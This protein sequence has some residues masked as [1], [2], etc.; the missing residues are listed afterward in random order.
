MD[1]V[2]EKEYYSHEEAS[3]YRNAVVKLKKAL[4]D[5]SIEYILNYSPGSLALR[6]ETV[7]CDCYDLMDGKKEAVRSFLGDYMTNYAWAASGA[8]T[9]VFLK[10]KFDPTAGDELYDL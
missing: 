10:Q 2:W 5:A 7:E 6:R 3:K 8:G 9:L 1:I 4:R